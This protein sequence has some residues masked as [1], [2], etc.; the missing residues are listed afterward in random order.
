MHREQ[1][2]NEKQYAINYDAT[3]KT[4]F[5]TFINCLSFPLMKPSCNQLSSFDLW[6]VGNSSLFIRSSLLVTLS[7]YILDEHRCYNNIITLI[8]LKKYIILI[9]SFLFK[10][11]ESPHQ[12]TTNLLFAF[13]IKDVI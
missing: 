3:C 8:K 5:L 11:F 4:N 7:S 1:N 12:T 2:L 6:L 13:S 10:N 9:V